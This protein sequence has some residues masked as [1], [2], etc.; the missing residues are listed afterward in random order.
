MKATLATT[1]LLIL[2]LGWNSEAVQVQVS[3]SLHMSD[4]CDVPEGAA[5]PRQCDSVR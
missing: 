2:A 5:S 4:E 1:A 3:A